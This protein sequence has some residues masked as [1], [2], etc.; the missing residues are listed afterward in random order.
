MGST[1]FKFHPYAEIFPLLEGQEFEDLVADITAHG[2]HQPIVVYED[3]VLDGRNRYRACVAAGV[4]CCTTLYTGDDPLGYVI[5]LNLKRR[6]LTATQRRDLI[7]KLVKAKPEA[8]NLQIAKQVKADDKTVAKVR[9]DLEARS[10]IP[11]VE[12]RTDTKGRKQA[13]H[14]STNTTPKLRRPSGRRQIVTELNSLAW[15][16]ASHSKPTEFVRNVGLV[17]IWEVADDDQRSA[18]KAAIGEIIEQHIARAKA[19]NP[20]IPPVRYSEAPPF[21]RPRIS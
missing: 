9:S 1:D 12:K 13:A 7:A 8:S 10:E 16:N 21:R 15:S 6:H 19:A 11:N 3:K 17:H 2:L 14:K 18:L 4:D 20:T 5:S